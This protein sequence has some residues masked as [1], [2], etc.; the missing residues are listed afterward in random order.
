MSSCW[1]DLFRILEQI[2]EQIYWLALP[3]KY[4]CLHSVFPVQLLEDYCWHH[5]DTELMIMPDL[6]DFQN[7]WNV[8][9][10]RNKWQIQ[11]IIYYLIKWADWFFEYNFYKFMSHLTDALKAVTDY[12]QKL[13]HKHKKISQININ[14]VSDSENALCKQMSSHMF[15]IL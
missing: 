4:D 10:V 8:K 14:K 13:K 11:N 7:E 3:M 15:L 6:E 9:K 5:D 1:I 2:D 12:K